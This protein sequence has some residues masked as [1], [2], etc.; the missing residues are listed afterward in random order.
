MADSHADIVKQFEADWESERDNRDDAMSDLQFLAGDQWPASVRKAR[1]AE[2]RPVLTINRMSQFVAQVSGNLRQSYPS[3]VPVPV[4][5]GSDKNLTDIYAGLVRQIEYL[6]GAGSAYAWGAQCSISCGV[7]HWRVDTE[8]SDN[9]GFDQD[10]CIKRIMDPLSVVWDAGATEI[11][12]SDAWHCTVTEMIPLSEYKRRFP[13]QKKEP[14]DFPT[15]GDSSG[16]LYWGD[17]DKVRIASYWCKKPVKKTL[18]ITQEGRV[19]DLSKLPGVAIQSLGIIRTRDVEA[20]KIMHQLMDGNDFLSDEQDWAGC[21]IPVIPCFGNEIAYDG[22][23]VRHGIIRWA[24]DPQRLY[25]YFRSAAAEAIGLAPKAPWLAPLQA[26][27]GLERYWERANTA[28]LPYLPYK[29]IPETP[30]AKP[31]RT[32]PA[33]PPASMWQEAEIAENDMKSTTG[34]YDAALGQ[35]SNETSGVAIEAR[36][37]QTDNSS[38]VYFDNFNYAIRRTGQILVDLIPKIY[39]GERVIRILG[40]DEQEA[41]VPINQSVQTIDGPALVNDLSAGKFD[42]RVKTGPSYV[43]AR[44]QAREELGKIIQADPQIMNV[45]GDLYFE[46]QDFPLAEKLAERFKKAIPP[47]L[48]QE[49]P[50]Q[51]DQGQQ[52]AMQAQ[53]AELQAKIEKMKAETFDKEQSGISKQI[54]NQAKAASLAT[55]GPEPPAH[56]QKEADRQFQSQEADKGRF[57]Q[58]HEAERGRQHAF[59]EAERGRENANAEAERGRQFS[60]QERRETAAVQPA[61]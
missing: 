57:A 17:G 15:L 10:I 11:D 36:Q 16:S 38:F 25:N 50:Q 28:N 18:G 14:T 34:V 51:P 52:M 59:T 7:G 8:Y 23:V 46:A 39:D 22:K 26:I 12:R 32:Q 2:G 58:A 20:Y 33:A 6:S 35:R 21:Y 3:I 60:R 56:V 27:E 44:Q 48:T 31:E 19:F 47:G 43:N 4:D 45:I 42:V 61:K 54:D 13:E 53:I 55:F 1:E 37:Q 24:K 49:G 9:D 29:V 5:G 30:L 40:T 41:F